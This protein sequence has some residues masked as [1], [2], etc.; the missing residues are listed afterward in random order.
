MAAKQEAHP[1]VIGLTSDDIKKC[2]NI[3]IREVQRT[4]TNGRT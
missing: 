1:E 3:G 4:G 2:T